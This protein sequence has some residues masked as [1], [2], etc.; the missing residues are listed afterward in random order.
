MNRRILAATCLAVIA[1][2]SLAAAPPG[3]GA[4]KALQDIHVEDGRFVDADG[5]TVLLRGVNVIDKWR[6]AGDGNLV[7]DF[8][9]SDAARLRDAGFNSVR[10][11]ITWDAVEQTRG[12]YDQAYLAEIRRLLDLLMDHQIVA[13]LDM[14]QDVWSEYI[15]SDGAPQWADPQCNV[16]PS[17]PLSET[18]GQWVA[19]YGSPDVEA[20]WANFWNDGFGAA[21]PFCT[22]PVQS[23]FVNTWGRVAASLGDHPALVGYDVLNEPWPSSPPGVFEQVHLYPFYE[24]V[25]ETI[26]GTDPDAI[27]FYEPPIWKSA[28]VPSAVLE[29]PADNS[30]YAPHIYTETMFS[31]GQASTGATSDEL[32]LLTDVDEA[33]RLGSALWVGEWGAFENEAAATY[34]RQMYDLFDRYQVS[35]AYW[36]YTQGAGSAT[37]QGQGV[38]AEVGHVRVYPEAWPGEATWTWDPD[39]RTFTM[40]VTVADDRPHEVRLVVPA[41][42]WMDTDVAGTRWHPGSGRL[43][44]VV[45]GAG[46]HTLQLTPVAVSGL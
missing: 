18:T 9:E 42:L 26:R 27:I 22:G 15:G 34:Q 40:T 21:D 20:A 13:V 4:V 43:R 28:M 36:T 38:P 32:V 19:Q 16:P 31:G 30:A 6:F 14:H 8:D 25:A 10:L 7:P 3:K 1:V 46:T 17:V 37:L 41:R 12:T 39:A 11:G 29:A 35:S 23:A 5:R 2:S 33:Q 44:W 45:E 24:L